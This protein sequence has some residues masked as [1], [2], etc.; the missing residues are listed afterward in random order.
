MSNSRSDTA[1]IFS[2]SASVVRTGNGGS[3]ARAVAAIHRSLSPTGVPAR[4]RSA[5][6]S[7]YV[8]ATVTLP[9]R[10]PYG[11]KE[12][13]SASILCG[14]HPAA[15]APRRA[16]PIVTKLRNRNRPSAMRRRGSH[17]PPRPVPDVRTHSY[18]PQARSLGETQGSR[19]DRREELRPLSGGHA[20][21]NEGTRICNRGQPLV[22]DELSDR[23]C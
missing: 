7:A 11:R 3:W 19:V 18:P 9:E 8:R 21:D 13:S 6:S 12:L 20:F 10:T 5:Q 16:S 15:L 1:A 23:R 22:L 17:S 14:L 4:L 2:K